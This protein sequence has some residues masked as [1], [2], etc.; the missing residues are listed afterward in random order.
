MNEPALRSW[1]WISGL[2]G[3]MV[4]ALLVWQLFFSGPPVPT[5]DH[6]Q[7]RIIAEE[8]LRLLRDGHAGEAWDATHTEFKSYRGKESFLRFVKSKHTLKDQARFDPVAEVD[9]SNRTI[10][11]YIFRPY[12]GEGKIILLL[13]PEGETWRIANI[14]VE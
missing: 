13:A 2:A 1:Y 4:V 10:R 11:Y 7:G 12:P 6:N 5:I 3:V 8:F 9:N 14:V